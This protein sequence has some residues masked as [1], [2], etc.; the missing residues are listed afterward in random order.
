MI[1]IFGISGAFR[2]IEL[3]NLDVK[4]VTE[5]GQMYNVVLMKTKNKKDRSFSID[6]L[7]YST[8]SHYISLRSKNTKTTRFFMH[9][10]DGKCTNQVNIDL[11]G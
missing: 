7:F 8:V 4:D 6:P 1:L 2:C 11:L 9:Y 5:H 10:N 3:T